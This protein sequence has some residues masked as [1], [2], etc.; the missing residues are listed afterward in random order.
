MGDFRRSRSKVWWSNYAEED[1]EENRIVSWEGAGHVLSPRGS[2]SSPSSSHKSQDSGFSDSEASSTPASSGE[3]FKPSPLP[4]QETDHNVSPAEDPQ[5]VTGLRQDCECPKAED[6]IPEG[7]GHVR[8]KSPA[9]KL[10]GQLFSQCVCLRRTPRNDT[11]ESTT[12]NADEQAKNNSESPHRSVD[13]TT[14]LPV[15][16]LR[17]KFLHDCISLNQAD[18]PYKSHTDKPT[19]A[20]RTEKPT[21][22]KL[23][24][25]SE[26][27]AVAETDDVSEQYLQ[28]R[29]DPEEIPT[30]ETSNTLDECVNSTLNPDEKKLQNRRQSSLNRSVAIPTIRSPQRNQ[31]E[32]PSKSVRESPVASP[33]SLKNECLSHSYCNTSK[34]SPSRPLEE[35]LNHLHS[36]PKQTNENQNVSI[37]AVTSQGCSSNQRTPSV[38]P[39]S[40]N[41]LLHQS[42]AGEHTTGSPKSSSSHGEVQS[43]K[44]LSSELPEH[45]GS[46]THTS[47]PKTTSVV[48]T[49]S[50]LLV[51]PNRP[52]RSPGSG[53][54]HGRPVNLLNNFNR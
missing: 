46:P 43:V 53:K 22:Q 5:E 7:P 11:R 1:T 45:L 35:R 39:R 3:S 10:K 16:K 9:S 14:Q 2:S 47:T 24:Q 26:D 6:T 51:T 30:K 4:S 8:S 44:P 33:R 13:C 41:H 15:K 21:R 49:P 50:K 42:S 12:V 19:S 20:L 18:S 37:Q 25:S 38:N 48:A 27:C 40:P 17:E 28:Q 36:P 34:L 32:S 54:K 52:L 31:K 29:Q 23:H